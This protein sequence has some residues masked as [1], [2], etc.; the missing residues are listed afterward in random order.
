MIPFEPVHVWDTSAT[1]R[2]LGDAEG[3]AYFLVLRWPNRQI[4]TI[5]YRA[6]QVAALDVLSGHAAADE[7]RRAFVV[8]ADE[9]G[10]LV[11]A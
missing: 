11:R 10:I 9:A 4:G 6:A 7:F 2:T 8:A 3:A 5:A 1:R